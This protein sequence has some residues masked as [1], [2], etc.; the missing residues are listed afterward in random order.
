MDTTLHPDSPSGVIRAAAHPLK[1][2]FTSDAR[3]GQLLTIGVGGDTVRLA[4][5][6]PGRRA[7]SA[8]VADQ[9]RGR[10]KLSFSAILPDTDLHYE[11]TAGA[12]KETIVLRQQPVD[13]RWRFR[14]T[15]GS[16]TPVMSAGGGIQLRDNKG[17]TLLVLPPVEAWDSRSDGNRP[18]AT[19]GGRYELQR[20]AG[21]WLLTVVVDDQWLRA[22]D[23]VYPVYVDP[24]LT[25]GV[26]DSFAYRSDGYDCNRC[27]LRVG[28]SR[29]NGDSYNRSVFRVD[30][31]SMM[32]KNVVGARLDVWRVAGHVG[33][34]ASLNVDM[35]HASA[36]DYD[37]VG[38]HLATGVVGENGSISGD[39]LTE[40]LRE[41]VRTGHRDAWFM[42]IGDER[43]GAWTYKHLDAV[44][45]V[46][47]GAAPPAAELRAPA[48]DSVVTTMTPTLSVSPVSDPD[49]EPVKYCFR[50]GT[51][52]DAQSGMLVESGCIDKPTWTVPAGVL[53]DGVAYT[54]QAWTASNLTVTKPQWVGR[55]RVDQRIGADNPAPDDGFA[56]VGVNLA[57]GN[58]TV[59]ASSPTFPTL[60]GATGLSYSYNSQ[61]AVLRGVTAEY[62]VD[63]NRN[64]A[65]DDGNQPSLVRQEPSVNVDYGLGSPHAPAIPPDWWIVRWVGYFQAPETG[66]YQFAGV[67]DDGLN[68]WANGQHVYRGTGVS[69]LN[70]SAEQA[71]GRVSLTRGQRIPIKVELAE[72]TW[73]AFAKLFVRT[74]DGTVVP[75]QLVSADWL[76]AEDVP[77]LPEGWT[78]SADIDGHGD[79]YV[80]AE[81]T[82]QTIVLTDNSGAKHTWTRKS[83]GGYQPPSGEDGVLALNADGRIA[84]LDDG[85]IYV[86]GTDGRIES[87]SS[88]HDASKPA[89]L[90]H[91]Y[92]GAPRRLKEIQDPVSGRAMRLHYNRP[93]DNCYPQ[94]T[95]PPGADANA[96]AQK[97]CRVEYWDGTQTVLWYGRGNLARI[98]DPGAEI[99]DFGYTS[100]GI[101]D[102]LRDPL[103]NDWIAA[104]FTNR[105]P[106]PTVMTAITYVQHGGKR[107]VASVT[108]P[109]PSPGQARPAHTYRYVSETE[110]Q[111]DAAGISPSTGYIRKVTFDDAYRTQT[112][113]DATGRVSRFEWDAKDRLI[114]TTDPAGR[115]STTLYDHADRPVAS[116]GP[117]PQNCFWG[118]EP[119]TSCAPLMPGSYTKYDEGINGLA[120]AYYDNE[121]LAGAPKAYS[122]GVGDASGRLA[123][124]WGTDA[125]I[126]GIGADHWSARFSGEIA[127]PRS[128]SYKIRVLA[129][130]GIR[131]W[132]DDR[133]LIDDWVA[134]TPKWREATVQIDEATGGPP[135]PR[136]VR[137]DYYEVDLGAKLELHWTKPDGTA[138]LIPGTNLHPRYGLATTNGERDVYDDAPEEI[139]RTEYGVPHFGLATSLTVDPDGLRLTSRTTYERAGE[140]YLRRTERT[141]PAGNTWTYAYYGDREERD[142]PCTAAV[143]PANQAGMGKLTTDPAGADGGSRA[144][145]VVYDKGGSVVATRIGAEPWACSEFDARGRLIH[146]TIPGVEGKPARTV[147]YEHSVNGDPLV[148][149]V[150]DPVGSITTRLDLLGRIVAYTDTSGATT[151]TTYDLAGRPIRATTTV[152]SF[153]TSVTSE[154]DDA[155][156]LNKVLLDGDLVATATYNDAGELSAVRYGNETALTEVKRDPAGRAIGMTWRLADGRTIADT[157]TRSVS[158]KMRTAT[159][160]ENG[161]TIA[162]SSYAYDAAGRLVRASLPN[163]EVSYRFDSVGGC[164]PSATAGANSNRTHLEERKSGAAPVVTTYCYDRA[165]RLVSTS[166]AMT[167]S[168]TYDNHGNTHQLGD[169]TYDYDGA[170]R[171]IATQNSNGTAIAY[172]RDA[173]DRL[174]ARTVTGAPTESANGV[175]RYAYTGSGGTADLILDGAGNLI[176]QVVALPGGG[177]LSKPVTG[178][179]RW[180]YPNLHGDV[181]LTADSNGRKTG[182]LQVYDPFGGQLDSSTGD[183]RRQ[184]VL[185]TGG[186]DNGWLGQ[187]QRPVENLSGLQALEMGSRVYLPA[188]GRFLEADPVEG[189]SSNDYEYAD[190]DPINNSDLDGNA[191]SKSKGY[192]CIGKTAS[193]KRL[194]KCKQAKR[195]NMS[196]E[197]KRKFHAS[198]G[199]RC[200]SCGKKVKQWYRVP[201]G[202]AAHDAAEVG[203]M[204]ALGKGGTNRR[205]NLITQCHAC[206]HKAQD[207]I[208]FERIEAR[209]LLNQMRAAHH[210]WDRWVVRVP[211]KVKNPRAGSIRIAPLGRGSGG[212][213]FAYLL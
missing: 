199:W 186:L 39:G 178:P 73:S 75:A 162:T 72:R 46:D 192:A 13:N 135:R 140:G 12:V 85:D 165:D 109:P 24:T 148:S 90:R 29:Y 124:D 104:D 138:E 171:H 203:H 38:K 98:E 131:L 89:S 177:L 77:A 51:G 129:D 47:F 7:S 57:N 54:W 126:Q 122:T 55:F 50:L 156:R 48:D 172:S 3:D 64:G 96:P 18:P 208:T 82:E 42:L 79:S 52:S 106:D 123:R 74:E 201:N 167:L 36:L 183:I 100:D 25:Y 166:G 92:A 59:N 66:T 152:K 115:K 132:L 103:V 34:Q 168:P 16:L 78:L 87:Q 33:T 35:F 150:T 139:T 114:A 86:F 97:L 53:R 190:G 185:P 44:L 37:G 170:D 159:V 180:G 4:L 184:P 32:N 45:L 207:N 188:L 112:E 27:G 147:R 40:F 119:S 61:Q 121:T 154:Y 145:E 11:V 158:G 31:A 94:L 80:T 163:R 179:S 120:A 28:N 212:R 130:D 136:R 143:D 19:T 127:F 69:D 22:K 67:H 125:P 60:A 191:S 26:V 169:D 187:H 174:V 118:T 6:Q 63:V 211:W 142:N 111:V 49:G 205:S 149:R 134:T 105:W 200:Q 198:N 23:R 204:R 153:S 15:T 128:G 68:V 189:G 62:Y 160:T 9:G 10:G 21:G 95:P 116:W 41:L 101:L 5:D 173:A 91:V 209:R 56:G 70:W 164:G 17:K 194:P 1:P 137:L 144:A 193:G 71:I 146:R 202:G 141:L 213:F 113:T 161:A 58:V 88:V 14:M 81:Q 110:T 157:V 197:W 155:G 83:A 117:W 2:T 99:T 175:F 107:K 206:N 43:S 176:E 84:L 30:Y 151:S 181:F 102:K 20:D 133:L 108:A 195:A 182:E 8:V 93:G 76:F 210:E 196:P 65:I